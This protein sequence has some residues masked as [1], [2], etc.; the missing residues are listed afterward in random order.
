M[1]FTRQRYLRNFAVVC[2]IAC[3]GV[4]PARANQQSRPVDT[5]PASR[6][7]AVNLNN[8]QVKGIKELV[9]TLQIVKIAL[10]RP[11]DN[12]PKHVDDMVCELKT[13]LR[14]SLDCGTQGWYRMRRTKW[15]LAFACG[16]DAE[17]PTIGHPWHSV[18]YLSH[19]QLMYL[20]RLL[21]R[22]PPP[23]SAQNI[24]VSMDNTTK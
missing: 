14:P 18:H 12:N 21:G 22:L 3:S 13:G 1:D 9:R 10:K 19:T 20:R 16:C 5:S 8:V 6:A 11:Y 15:Q 7:A 4:A 2:A 23:G 17:S 24:L